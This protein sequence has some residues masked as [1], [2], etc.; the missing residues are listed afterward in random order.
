[1]R[2]RFVVCVLGLAIATP[3]FAAEFRHLSEEDG[4]RLE[5]AQLEIQLLEE[6][7]ARLKER[8]IRFA[9]DLQRRDGAGGYSL[10]LRCR[11]WLKPPDVPKRDDEP[12]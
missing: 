1:M 10:D 9:Q 3:C 12:C 6:R 11:R 4:L 7:T 8:A 5:K 2:M